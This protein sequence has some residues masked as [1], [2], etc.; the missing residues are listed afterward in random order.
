MSFQACREL[1]LVHER[2]PHHTVVAGAA[3]AI[4]DTQSAVVAPPRPSVL[5]FPALEENVPWLEEWLLCHFSGSAFDTNRSPLP[6]M[7]G[8]Q[9]TIHLLPDA[10]PYACHTPASVSKH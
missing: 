7:V 8:E 2:F 6:V 3:P 9:H 1:G 5:Q 4:S 10:K